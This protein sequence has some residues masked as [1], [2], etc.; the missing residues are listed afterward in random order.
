MGI[1]II[2]SLVVVIVLW[3]V[4]LS[5]ETEGVLLTAF[6]LSVVLFIHTLSY[7]LMKHNYISLE[8]EGKAIQSTLDDSRL[9]NRNYEKATVTIKIITYN[10]ELSKKQAL[11]NTIFGLYIDNRVKDLKQVK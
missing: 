1:F 11:A 6:L 7:T 4:G 9:N 2:I 8:A 3:I 5:T 10:G